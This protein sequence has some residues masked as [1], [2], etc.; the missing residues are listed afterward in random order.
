M[1][2]TK[3][4]KAEINSL[5]RLNP[6][7]TVF[8]TYG[9][10][11]DVFFNMYRPFATKFLERMGGTAFHIALFNALPGLGAALVILPGAIILSRRKSA[12]KLTSIFFLISRL[13]ILLI[14]FV[15]TFPIE[16]QPLL[17]IL[18]ISLMNLP[19]A[20]AQTS[21]QS[22]LGVVFDGRVRST[23]ITLR[24][25]FGNIAVPAITLATGLIIGLLPRSDA[26][27]ILYYQSFY[28]AAF[29]ISLFEISR[30]LKLKELPLKKMASPLPTPV[31]EE[32]KSKPGFKTALQITKEPKFKLFLITTMV[33]QFTWQAGWPIVTIYQIKTLGANELWLAAFAVIA[34]ITSF[35]CA[36]RWNKLIYKRSN[37]LALIIAAFFMAVNMFLFAAAPSLPVLLI[38]SVF[39]GISTI[40][41]NIT[42]LNGMLEATPSEN[43]II[44]IA[45]YNTF[46]NISLFLSPFFAN[47]ILELTGITNALMLIGVARA[48][49][50]GLLLVV[51]LRAKKAS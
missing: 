38:V 46:A 32:P 28:V 18:F 5:N 26:E 20:V 47:A 21:L 44:A 3:R 7:I 12:Q 8:I 11:F 29:I 41:L 25:K 16:L 39:T 49:A 19:E 9:L 43:R 42:L 13:F 30:F 2:V 48:L 23:A 37:G 50:G 10:L 1:S 15:P 40:G 22:F 27:R 45:V 51:Y 17:F 31:E 24:N 34:G 4:I 33:F 6:N 35:L 36:G 14:A